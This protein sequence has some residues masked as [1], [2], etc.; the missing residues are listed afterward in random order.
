LFQTQQSAAS[1]ELI[2]TITDAEIGL[3]NVV[4]S[5]LAWYDSNNGEI[6]DICNQQQTSFAGTDN[7]IYTIQKE[8][9]NL[10]NDCITT[11][12]TTLPTAGLHLWLRAD[13]GIV[14]AGGTQIAH[15]N[16]QSGNGRN[17]SMTTTTRQPSLVSGALN[18][19]PVVRFSGAQSMYLDISSTPT[20]FSVFVVGK[21]NLAIESFNMILGPGGNSPNDQLRWNNGSQALF[22]TQ[23]AGTIITSTIGNTRVYHALSARYDGA[24]I[25]FYRDGNVTSSSPF[26]TTVPWTISSV[27]SWYSTYY[28]TGDLAEVIIYDRAPSEADRQTVNSYLH[29]KYNLP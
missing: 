7:N 10:Q 28:M 17:A 20:T 3:T 21:N 24:N 15:W 2:E 29:S 16:D 23:N 1:H 5:P 25:T 13:A 4:A 12:G 22:V 19:L 26:T 14:P 27:G 6:G 11:R 8:F 18:G 9:S